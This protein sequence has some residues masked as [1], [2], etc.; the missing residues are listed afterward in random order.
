MGGTCLDVH[1]YLLSIMH[2]MLKKWVGSV[3][4]CALICCQSCIQCYRYGWD[5]YG[6][7]FSSAVNHAFNVLEMGGTCSS[8]HI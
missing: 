5:M 6:I 1:F 4:V 2:S 8:M 3:L 7:A